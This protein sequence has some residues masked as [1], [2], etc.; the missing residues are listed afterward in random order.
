MSETVTSPSRRPTVSIATARN[1]RPALPQGMHNPCTGEVDYTED[2]LEFLMA[3]DRY[4][5]VMHRPFPTWRELH[6]VVLSLGYRKV[7]TNTLDELLR[8]IKNAPADN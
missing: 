1:K 6:R 4:K 5:R 2:E 7:D 8:H 3:I